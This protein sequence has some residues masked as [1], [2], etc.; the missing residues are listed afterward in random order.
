VLLLFLHQPMLG[1]FSAFPGL[2]DFLS[3]RPS[4]LFPAVRGGYLN[5]NNWRRDAWAPAVRAAGLEHRPPY[6]L[7]HTFAAWA[8]AAGIGLFELTRMMGTS[9][10]QIART[11]GHLLPD[12]LD[13]ARAALMGF[14]RSALTK[15]RR[16]NKDEVGEREDGDP[17]RQ[18]LDIA[19]P[20]VGSAPVELFA[21]T[22]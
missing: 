14:L 4:L 2:L 18:A 19:I 3:P 15:E 17:K 12:S 10:E 1:F 7:R 11:Y 6:A 20:A 16:C 13:R 8:I 22:L 5:L 9:V 21:P